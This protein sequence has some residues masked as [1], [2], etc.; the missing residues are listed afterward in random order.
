MNTSTGRISRKNARITFQK[1]SISSDQYKNQIQSWTDYF[2]CS[3][4]ASTFVAQEDGEKVIY[5]NRSVTF[6][7]RYCP[8]LAAVNSTEYQILFEGEQY[9]ILSIDPM[10]YQKK[11]L[12]FT[13]K[14]EKRQEAKA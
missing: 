13:C 11:E 8:E 14:R 10:N 7:T 4:Y 5:E 3:A 1:N 9:N 12:R 6:E 2:T